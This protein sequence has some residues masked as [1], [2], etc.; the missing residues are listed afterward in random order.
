MKIGYDRSTFINLLK[1]D[2]LQGEIKLSDYLA[3]IP[4]DHL[5]SFT[6]VNNGYGYFVLRYMV[7][8]GSLKAKVAVAKALKKAPYVESKKFF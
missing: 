8:S 3:E 5:K 2:D 6:S 1:L 4:I 7:E